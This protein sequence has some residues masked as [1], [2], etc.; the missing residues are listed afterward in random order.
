MAASWTAPD[1]SHQM[2]CEAQTPF[3]ALFVR[4]LVK[5][6]NVTPQVRRRVFASRAQWSD[7]QKAWILEGGW[8]REGDRR[9]GLLNCR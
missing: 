3:E 6:R 4:R 1:V 9:K 5:K 2:V 8:E 7:S